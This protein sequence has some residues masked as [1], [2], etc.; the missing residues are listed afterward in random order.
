MQ[1]NIRPLA[2]SVS[3][4][5]MEDS[6]DFDWRAVSFLGISDPADLRSN[7]WW[8]YET[9]KRPD[10]W[11]TNDID[12]PADRMITHIGELNDATFW[13]PFARHYWRLSAVIIICICLFYGGPIRFNRTSDN[14]TFWYISC[15]VFCPAQPSLY[16]LWMIKIHKIL[17]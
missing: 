2:G 5:S 3:G 4:D 17:K 6:D 1:G 12:P 16:Y 8:N 7:L 10:G 14:R 15:T 9:G 13:W 11:Y